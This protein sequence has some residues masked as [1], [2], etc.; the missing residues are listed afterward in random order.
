MAVWPGI[1]DGVE[2]VGKLVSDSSGIGAIV[3]ANLLAGKYQLWVALSEEREVY[4][5]LIT[6]VST[7]SLSGDC[8]LQIEMVYGFRQSTEEVV[9]EVFAKLKAFAKENHCNFISATTSIERA[10]ELMQL[11]GMKETSRNYAIK[12]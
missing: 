12:I 5:F 11:V 4:G 3:L 10:I 2:Q 6:C 7:D 9:F 8:Y 1:R